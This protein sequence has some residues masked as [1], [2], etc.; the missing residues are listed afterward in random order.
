MSRS[1]RDLTTKNDP[2]RGPWA[3]MRGARGQAEAIQKKNPPAK[4]SQLT[5]EALK[6]FGPGKYDTVRGRRK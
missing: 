3:P 5:H 1:K 6:G 4:S 2:L